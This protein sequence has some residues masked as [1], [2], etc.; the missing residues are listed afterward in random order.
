MFV[1]HELCINYILY[2]LIQME[3]DTVLVYDCPLDHI[4]LEYDT[5]FV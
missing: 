3:Y 4:R 2:G 5:V 1:H